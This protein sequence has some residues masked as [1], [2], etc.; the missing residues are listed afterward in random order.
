[1]KVGR[2]GTWVRCDADTDVVPVE[3]KS[4]ATTE[5]CATDRWLGTVTIPRDGHGVGGGSSVEFVVAAR[6]SVGGV[7]ETD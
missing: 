4:F 3:D 6:I 1:M 5:R 7:E 2:L